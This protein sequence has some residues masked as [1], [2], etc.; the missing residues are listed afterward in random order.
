MISNVTLIILLLF[1][2]ALWVG[3][4]SPGSEDSSRRPT[5]VFELLPEYVTHVEEYAVDEILGGR[6]PDAFVEE[7]QADWSGLRFGDVLT[8][9]DVDN[10]VRSGTKDVAVIFISGPLDEAGVKAWLE[11]DELWE[12]SSYHSEELWESEPHAMTFLES[13]GYLVYGDVDLI[14]DVIKVK[15][16]GA[17]SLAEDPENKLVQIMDGAS[18]W[19]DWGIESDCRRAFGGNL[20]SCEGTL[21]SA[22]H[23]NKEYLV[24]IT[25]R[26]LFRTERRAEDAEFPVEDLVEKTLGR[27]A[28]LEEV[29]TRGKL[30]EVKVT[31]DQADFQNKWLNP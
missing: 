3:A 29:K 24:E 19:F 27:R 10:V 25:Y 1:L 16:R 21:V 31:A 14:K 6:V 8:I 9:D 11:E 28:D 2:M 5:N 4:C 7:F 15:K 13:D 18:G 22:A 20:R 26:F 12:R 30:V 23:G 17:G